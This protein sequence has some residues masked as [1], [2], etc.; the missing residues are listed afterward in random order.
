M[1]QKVFPL[2]FS[3]LDNSK[4]NS[5]G[6]GVPEPIKNR[7]LGELKCGRNACGVNPQREMTN[8]YRWHVKWKP[9]SWCHFSGNFWSVRCDYVNTLNHPWNA[10]ASQELMLEHPSGFG[11]RQGSRGDHIHR[12][13]RA[14]GRYFCE[15][16]G[17]SCHRW[18]LTPMQSSGGR[19]DTSQTLPVCGTERTWRLWRRRRNAL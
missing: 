5:T 15:C 2:G 13:S 17:F 4:A 10:D 8:E 14:W 7:C 16:G 11:G 3:P 12:D 18:P 9:A 19:T 6:A 1:L